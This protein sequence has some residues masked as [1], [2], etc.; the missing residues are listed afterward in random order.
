MVD[1]VEDGILDAASQLMG[2][3]TSRDEETMSFTNADAM[4][5]GARW[6]VARGTD[7]RR[8]GRR[9]RALSRPWRRE[10]R[11]E[12]ALVRYGVGILRTQPYY[13]TYS[14]TVQD[15]TRVFSSGQTSHV[16]KTHRERVEGVR[17]PLSL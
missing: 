14:R 2:S 8:P 6:R 17:E 16:E 13:V 3:A 5:K 7:A 11:A 4:A 1:D 9:A 10:P 15:A 12:H